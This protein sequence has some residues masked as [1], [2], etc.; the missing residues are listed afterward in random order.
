MI[1]PTIHMNGTS[2]NDLLEG[3]LKMSH[4]LNA[5][6]TA[7]V[8]EGPNGRD[9]YTQG[10]GVFYKAQDEQRERIKKIAAVKE[11]IDTIVEH[12]ADA[13]GGRE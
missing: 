7:M 6:I 13:E 1:L 5:A 3:W 4:A 2:K 11:E 8:E 10:D 12:I 9:Y